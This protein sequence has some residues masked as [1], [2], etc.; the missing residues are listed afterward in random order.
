VVSVEAVA[1]SP[2]SADASVDVSGS[3][4]VLVVSVDESSISGVS[5]AVEE[6][7]VSVDASVD[8]SAAVAVA[9]ADSVG[10]AAATCIFRSILS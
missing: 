10:S 3:V 6:S 2:V 5:V 8:D 7:P 1:Q 9:V 4:V